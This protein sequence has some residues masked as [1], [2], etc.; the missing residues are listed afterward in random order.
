MNDQKSKMQMQTDIVL[1]SLTRNELQDLIREVLQ[2]ELSVV[3]QHKIEKE[4]MSFKETIQFLG[5]SR[6]TLNIWKS[7]GKLPFKKLGRRI[8]FSREEVL[9]ALKETGC[10]NKLKQLEVR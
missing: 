10:Y 7:Q 6:S 3:N 4:L 9:S 1:I 5:I 2:Q 8:F